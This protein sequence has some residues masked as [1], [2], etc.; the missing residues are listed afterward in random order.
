MCWSCVFCALRASTHEP[1]PLTTP[2]DITQ[3]EEK[4]TRYLLEL[5]V[6]CC[7]PPNTPH[8]QLQQISRSLRRQQNYALPVGVA[9]S[10]L[11][12]LQRMN[13]PHSQLQQI[14]RSLRR[15]ERVIC[16]SCVF[17]VALPPTTPPPQ[18]QQI[19]RN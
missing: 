7:L 5:R 4:S 1:T 8:T 9:C 12:A 2:T 11:C 15:K 17:T 6:H 10:V 13:P 16:S 18:L 3:F 14:S 19:T